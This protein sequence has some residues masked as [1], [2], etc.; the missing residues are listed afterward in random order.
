LKVF[1]RVKWHRAIEANVI[2]QRE[3]D[4]HPEYVK[5]IRARGVEDKI[6]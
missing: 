6:N 4:D 2:A 1:L 5:S 3:V